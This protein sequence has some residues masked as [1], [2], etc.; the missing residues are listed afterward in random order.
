MN[1]RSNAS[2][3]R[4]H[5]DIALLV[6][7]AL[8][9]AIALVACWYGV[10]AAE[11]EVLRY[12][13]EESARSWGIFLKEDL[14]DLPGILA[15]ETIS[16]GDQ[17][18]IDS[19]SEAGRIFRY[20]FFGA[21]GLIH[22]AS[23][24]EDIGQT[25]TKPYF[26][27]IVQKGGT[28]AKIEEEEEFGA[29]RTSV[30][31]AYVPIMDGETFLGAIEVYVDVTARAE[32]LSRLGR[33]VFYSLLGLLI[34][35]AG[36]MGQVVARNIRGHREAI[37]ALTE[38]EAGL[39]RTHV[40]LED[41]RERAEAANIAKSQFLA[42]MSHEIRTPM[43]GVLG[44]ADL[45][46]RTDLTE[47]QTHFLHTI[48]QSTGSLL[49]IINNI[50]DF[51]R[52][53]AGELELDHA[54]FDLHELAGDVSDLLAEPAD[55]K[56]LEFISFVAPEVPTMVYGDPARLRQVLINLLGNGVKFTEEG[57]VFLSVSSEGPAGGNA[58]V[59]FEVRDT[60]I[61]IDSEDLPHL[62]D[63]FKQA[64]A[65]VTRR[66]GGTGL[67]LS[68]AQQLVEMM[69][70]KI[71]V[72][73]APGQGTRFY[74]ALDLKVA[75]Q[76]HYSR[77]CRP[78]ELP[79]H[80]ILVV[81]DNETNREVLTCH[82]ESWRIRCTA[83]DSA[84]QGL[85]ELRRAKAEGQPYDLAI[86]DMMMPDMSGLD[87]AQLV[88]ADSSIS[89]CIMMLLTSVSWRGDH[90]EARRA[91]ISTILHK[92]LRRSELYNEIATLLGR[93]ARKM[94][95]PEASDRA[96]T[97][98]GRWSGRKVLLVEDSPV[99][100]DVQREY[101]EGLGFQVDIAGDG[102][103]AVAA[104]E[105]GRYDLILMDC[106]MPEM[107]GFEATRAIRAQ[108]ARRGDALQIPIIALTAHAFD[109]DRE[110]CLAAGMNDYLA[111]PFDRDQLEELL[112]PW[113]A[114]LAAQTAASPAE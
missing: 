94:A 111:K 51:S 15:G 80:R 69:G 65:S 47:R 70:S 86:L 79:G 103:V 26:T 71:E 5:G 106:Q 89:D 61:G 77:R 41:A 17:K 8:V 90:A 97:T 11:N 16:P 88:S 74:F 99:N 33:I 10:R 62:F 81:D 93:A 52:I 105:K 53:E 45:L 75:P 82:L 59:T 36:T 104:W 84:P 35:I 98:D 83:V 55:A 3:A 57:E 13:A 87:L 113:I 114:R 34:F 25:N 73:S 20:K 76:Q 48:Q 24:P 60:G 101:L 102:K 96:A 27:G 56:G 72:V 78:A 1:T 107:D 29:E 30:S 7:A 21:D 43:N 66:Y 63:S 39:R 91:G 85:E 58:K 18:I 31:E 42:N 110:D 109:K 14:G 67:G 19:A 46:S 40:E 32:E 37:Q 64:D 12:E 108:E 100:Q 38:S 4:R 54:E 95:E 50:L 68:I 49:T 2:P 28:F 6:A 44:M 22:H 92:P 23:R 112:E 9:G